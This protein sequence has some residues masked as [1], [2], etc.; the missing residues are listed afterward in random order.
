MLTGICRR[1]FVCIVGAAEFTLVPL[2]TQLSHLLIRQKYD[3]LESSFEYNSLACVVS[4]H[5][6]G[7]TISVQALKFSG[8]Q[9][10]RF[11]ENRHTKWVRLSALCT[12]R[13][14]SLEVFL[15]LIFVRS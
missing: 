3:Y 9:A 8:V 11:Q 5:K 6:T 7:R 14:Y 10:P 1:Q 4:K 2:R 12:S 15:V 13:P